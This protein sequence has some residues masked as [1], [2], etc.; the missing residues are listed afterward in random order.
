MKGSLVRLEMQ[1]KDVKALTQEAQVARCSKTRISGADNNDV[2]DLVGIVQ[3]TG[4]RDDS[5]ALNS[6]L[7]ASVRLP[8]VS[9]S[10]LGGHIERIRVILAEKSVLVVVNGWESFCLARWNPN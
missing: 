3:G 10:G 7:E 2:V 4:R 1:A 8:H 5:I 6:S 9:V